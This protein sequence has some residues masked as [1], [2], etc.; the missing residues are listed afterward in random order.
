MGLQAS[1]LHYTYSFLYQVFFHR[2]C[3]KRCP[4]SHR[5]PLDLSCSTPPL[6]RKIC[7]HASP[8]RTL[9]ACYKLYPEY[10]EG[11]RGLDTIY[12][13]LAW[14]WVCNWLI[15][16]RQH[17]IGRTSILNV[18]PVLLSTIAI[19]SGKFGQCNLDLQS[20]SQPW[21]SVRPVGWRMITDQSMRDDY[22]S[23]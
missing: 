19:Y 18:A 1:S 13:E 16:W 8:H 2:P 22:W 9:F 3:V 15:S 23:M 7:P 11:Q 21:P 5:R 20:R 4:K 17:C 14:I 10:C 12:W 6:G